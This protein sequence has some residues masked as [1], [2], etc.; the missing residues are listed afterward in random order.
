MISVSD[1]FKAIELLFKVGGKAAEDAEIERKKNAE[2][3]QIQKLRKKALRN[4]NE[5]TSLLFKTKINFNKVQALILSA[6]D[7][8]DSIGSV[9]DEILSELIRVEGML[10]TADQYENTSKKKVSKK[11]RSKKKASKK[12]RSKKKASK[13]KR[14][15]KKSSKK[16]RSKKKRS[17]KKRF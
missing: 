4:I 8:L 16:K 12:K 13:K 9:D 3:Q 11:K 2:K 17:K 15:K 5:A 7:A 1:I 14:S 6:H 10:E